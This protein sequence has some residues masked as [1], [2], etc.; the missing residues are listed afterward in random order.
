MKIILF[1]ILVIAV[2]WAPSLHDQYLIK[3][4]KL[5]GKSFV[6]KTTTN[7]IV[8]FGQKNIDG[9]LAYFKLTLKE[10]EILKKIKPKK[11]ITS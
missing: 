1:F 7:G 9:K 6:R 2:M 8:V 4:S 11:T 10:I 3:K 5:T